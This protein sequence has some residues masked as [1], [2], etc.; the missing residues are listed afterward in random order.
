MN[1]KILTSGFSI[2][3]SLALAGGATYATFTNLGTSSNNVFAA[4]TLDLKLANDAVTFSDD[5]TAT[6]GG[7]N[8]APNGSTVNGTLTLKNSGTVDASFVDL[9]FA[10]VLTQSGSLPGSVTTNPMDKYL[11]VTT[12]DY[13]GT[14][15][16]VSTVGDTNSNGYVDLED[17]AGATITN[18]PGITAGST[19]TLSMSVK[20]NTNAPNDVQ[21]DSVTTSLDVTLK[22]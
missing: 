14:D 2:L 22:Q 21:G 18:L 10:N 20:L 11:E 15:L 1:R 16:L 17:L 4:G 12:L 9:D 19:K 7:T 5:V 13:N 3:A 6:W 8:M